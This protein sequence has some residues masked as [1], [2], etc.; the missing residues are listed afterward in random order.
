[1]K[2]PSIS[3]VSPSATTIPTLTIYEDFD[4]IIAKEVCFTETGK[5]SFKMAKKPAKAIKFEIHIWHFVFFLFSTKQ[6][7]NKCEQLDKNSFAPQG[8]PV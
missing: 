2:A 5:F 1:M 7:L 8:K 3:S 4:K 6:N